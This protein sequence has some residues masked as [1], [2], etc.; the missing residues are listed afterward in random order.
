MKIKT[1]VE[2]SKMGVR[3]HYCDVINLTNWLNGLGEHG[4]ILIGSLQEEEEQSDI[5][6]YTTY[7]C[8]YRH[9]EKNS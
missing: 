8:F 3:H 7:G 5:G 9:I 6:Y 2:Y 1:Q 4:W